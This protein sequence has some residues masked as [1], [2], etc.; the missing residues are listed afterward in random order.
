MYLQQR[1]H[2]GRALAPV[3]SC[4]VAMVLASVASLVL[5]GTGGPT[6]AVQ[7][8]AG[9]AVAALV[10]VRLTAGRA[11]AWWARPVPGARRGVAP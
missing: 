1:E 6:V 11:R 9:L 8:L 4:A 10:G 3:T 5:A 2:R 7:V